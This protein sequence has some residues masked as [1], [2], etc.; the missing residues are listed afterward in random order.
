[1]SQIKEQAPFTL[2][3][4]LDGKAVVESSTDEGLRIEGYAAGFNTDRQDEAFMP[5]AFEKGLERYLNENPILCYHHHYDQALG[6]V[7]SA[8]LDGKGLF[9]K[10]RLDPP[11]P[12]TPLAD[13]YRKVKSGTIRGFSVG[14]IFKRKMTPHGPRIHTADIAEISVTP[15]P[16]EAGSLFALAG[17]AFGTDPD[18]ETK[19]TALSELFDDLG[20]LAG[21][22]MSAEKR[23][24]AKHHYPGTDKYPIDNKQDLKDAVGLVGNS[25]IPAADVKKYLIRVAK[26]EGWLDAIPEEWLK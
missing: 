24:N 14:G 18:L 20:E 3:F 13:V 7:E 17:K 2:D 11:E 16:M 22:A 12:N 9:V 6:V 19:I 21:K 8:K 10:A 26:A 23:R 25:S 15:L 1:M 4:A 5:G